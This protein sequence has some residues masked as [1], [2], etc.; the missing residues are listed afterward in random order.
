M[1]FS[2]PEYWSGLPFPSPADLPKPGIELRSPA[3]Q[4][5]SSPAEPQGK[6]KNARMG[7]LTLPQ[8]IFP[9]QE[10][11]QGPPTWQVDSLAPELPGKP[12]FKIKHT[13]IYINSP[14]PYSYSYIS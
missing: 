4:A 1:Q 9:T 7:N 5:D 6:P 3:L 8:E 14:G 11:N 12:H 10:L 13:L 2:G